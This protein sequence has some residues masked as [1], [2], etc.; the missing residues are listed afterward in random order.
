MIDQTTAVPT[1]PSI[2]LPCKYGH[3]TAAGDEYVITTPELPRPWGNI[4]TNGRYYSLCLH[5]GRGFSHYRNPRHFGLTRW[6]PTLANSLMRYVYVKDGQDV[7]CLNWEPLCKSFDSWECRVGF[8][9]TTLT[10]ARNGIHGRVIYTVPMKRDAEDWIISVKNTSATG[11]KLK[12]FTGVEPQL[13][14]MTVD[15]VTTRFMDLFLRMRQHDH[16][17]YAT[18]VVVTSEDPAVDRRQEWPWEVY[19]AATPRPTSFD[20]DHRSFMGLH[21]DA[22]NPQAVEDGRCRNS[23]TAGRQPIFAFHWDLALEPGEEKTLVVSMGVQRKGK[24]HPPIALEEARSDL[25]HTRAYWKDY[26]D[27][28]LQA[29]TPNPVVNLSLNKWNK[30]QCRI[31][32]WWYSASVT[33]YRF[34]GSIWGFRDSSQA[35]L[36]NTAVTSGLSAARLLEIGSHVFSNGRAVHLFSQEYADYLR[37]QPSQHPDITLWWVISVIDYLKETGDFELLTQVIPYQDGGDGTVYEHIKAILDCAAHN[38][39]Q[40]GLVRFEDGDWNDGMNLVGAQGKGVSVM[41]TQVLLYVVEQ[42]AQLN[43]HQENPAEERWARQVAGRLRRALNRYAWDGK[44]FVRAFDDRGRVIGSKRNK[45]GRVYLNPQSWAVIA[46]SSDE[47]RL[48][49]A[50]DAV[51]RNLYTEAGNILFWPAYDRPDNR[52]GIMTRF[53][54]GEKENAAI[55]QHAASWA[56]IAAA[57]LGRGAQAL[58]YYLASNPLWSGRHPDQY[59]CEPYAYCEYKT[60]PDSPH[61]GQG[62]HSWFTGAVPWMYRALSDYLLGIRP[63]LDGLRIDPC[64][65]ESWRG[66]WATRPFRGCRYRIQ[67]ENLSGTGHGVKKLLVDGIPVA[68]NIVPKPQGARQCTVLAEL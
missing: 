34:G 53:L 63:E 16:V 7:W 26:L 46:A 43:R 29:E 25:A 50:M 19:F 9:T 62:S 36:G 37:D 47:Q 41:L 65:P 31:N 4:L 3:F 11:K 56:V 35:V 54:P 42:W 10:S 20:M 14:D 68:G 8:G 55:F 17:L 1:E 22:R 18:S 39:G 6:G 13:G 2:Q 21:R 48:H 12:L 15:L 59:E 51:D 44:Y 64:I 60:G 28:G 27:H 32:F 33:Q 5:T 23:V 58:K 52:I 66:F 24:T 30:Y 38:T 40:K 57:L 61:F 49:A 67:V 45:A